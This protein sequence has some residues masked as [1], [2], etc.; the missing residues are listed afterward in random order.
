[1]K[2]EDK[3]GKALS[4]RAAGNIRPVMVG[5]ISFVGCFVFGFFTTAMVRDYALRDLPRADVPEALYRDGLAI[6][7]SCGGWS[8]SF[9]VAMLVALAAARL[10]KG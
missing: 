9:V 5:C 4:T 8:I 3:S 10:T 7:W 6:E 1:M 2:V